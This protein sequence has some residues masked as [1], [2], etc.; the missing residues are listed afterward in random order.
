MRIAVQHP[1][2]AFC[3]GLIAAELGVVD[4]EGLEVRGARKG[5]EGAV[6]ECSFVPARAEI[7]DVDGLK[8][9]LVAWTDDRE[10]PMEGVRVVEPEL[11]AIQDVDG[12]VVDLFADGQEVR[13]ERVQLPFF[14]WILDRLRFPTARSTLP[15]SFAPSIT[16]VI[17][18]EE[19]STDRASVR[20]SF[21]R[22][23]NAIPFGKGHLVNHVTKFGRQLHEWERLLSF[24]PRQG[25]LRLLLLWG[26]LGH[27]LGRSV[28]RT[29]RI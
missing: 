3:A 10:E 2:E 1:G 25:M 23:P 21:R 22:N 28:N 12:F 5:H 13:D 29:A 9:L 4:V 26:L 8:T 17:I 7:H 14:V 6:V 19:S 18:V 20:F 15:V 11:L 24:L 16:V 27:F